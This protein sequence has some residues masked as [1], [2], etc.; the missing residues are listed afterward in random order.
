MI[1]EESFQSALD[2]DPYNLPLRG[3]LADWL[4]DHGDGRAAGYR[5]MFANG[6]CPVCW[7]AAWYWSAEAKGAE[8]MLAFS[9]LPVKI[10]DRLMGGA[11]F[12]EGTRTYPN[13]LM[14]EIDL[15]VALWRMR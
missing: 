7:G 8:P 6:K 9:F 15:I 4:E 14:A 12:S 11:S 10:W 13:R 5:W 1:T 2:R 3:V